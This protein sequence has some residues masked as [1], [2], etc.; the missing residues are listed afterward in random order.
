MRRLEPFVLAI[1]EPHSPAPLAPLDCL[2]INDNHV[3]V[4]AALWTFHT[5]PHKPESPSW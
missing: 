5:S 2:L 4:A 1:I 3:H